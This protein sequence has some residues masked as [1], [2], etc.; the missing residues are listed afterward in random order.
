M[1]LLFNPYLCLVCVS[2][3]YVYCIIFG[4]SL[5]I[6]FPLAI[7]LSFVFSHAFE[8][9]VL[10]H[11]TVSDYLF[12]ILKIFFQRKLD[13]TSIKHRKLKTSNMNFTK[14]VKTHSYWFDGCRL[15]F[16]WVLKI[17]PSSNIQK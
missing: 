7:V 11:F 3:S 5:F 4:R 13:K 14:I 15:H 16:F 6:L 10:L 9:F 12:G 17:Y 8:L 2:Q 1:Y